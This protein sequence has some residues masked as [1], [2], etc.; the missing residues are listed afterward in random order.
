MTTEVNEAMS[1]LK[2]DALFDRFKVIGMQDMIV[3]YVQLS[4]ML[5]AGIDILFSLKTLAAQTANK[6]LK[7]V[8]NGVS[9][10]IQAGDSLSIA[11]SG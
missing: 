2:V 5:N 7:D 11:L 3:F 6:R 9:K 8:I 4:N 10:S 1:T